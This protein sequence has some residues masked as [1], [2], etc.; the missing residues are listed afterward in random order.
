MILKKKQIIVLIFLFLLTH[1]R[2]Q[3]NSHFS[4]YRQ[5]FNMLNPAFTGTEGGSIINMTFRSQWSGIKDSPETQ[6]ISFGT[7]TAGNRM[8]IGFSVIND[9]TFVEK[10]IQSFINFSY[11]LQLSNKLDLYLGIQSGGNFYSVNS[12]N[13]NVYGDSEITD[14]RLF[15]NYSR[16]NPNIGVGIYFKHENFYFSLSAPKILNSER[17]KRTE[18]ITSTPT[19]RV[20][21]YTTAGVFIPL[22]E[23]WEF[24]PSFLLSYVKAAPML[25]TLNATISYNKKIEFGTEYNFQSGLGGIIMI[26]TGKTFSF[27][28]AYITS[29][30]K[31]INT[32]STGTHEALLKIKIADFKAKTTIT[33]KSPNTPLSVKKINT[34]K[35]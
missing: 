6:V 18:G 31:E 9:K 28:Y 20:H 23:Q 7:P 22:N 27:G 16:I 32:F 4:L 21:T 5:H 30:Q 14:Q 3:Q 33:E 15:L 8:G 25:L 2:S 24:I 13:L 26:N 10:Q 29:M 12:S 1:L 34:I 11:R 19:D 17:F 35:K